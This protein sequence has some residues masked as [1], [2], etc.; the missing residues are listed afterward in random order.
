MTV[1]FENLLSLS[2]ISSFFII[3][4]FVLRLIFKKAKVPSYICCVMW[5][6]A[7][8]RLVFPF[9]IESRLS[10]VPRTLAVNMISADL[11]N[12]YDSGFASKASLNA[13]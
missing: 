8:I 11:S 12:A 6:L 7:A 9:S 1:F 2:M 13:P 3:A 4:V 5:V 10:L